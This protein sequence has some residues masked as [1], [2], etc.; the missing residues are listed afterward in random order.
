MIQSSLATK[1]QSFDLVKSEIEQTIRHAETSL[2]RFQE[3]RESGED[4]Q[5]CVDYLNQLRG[6]FVLVELRG[7]TLLCKEAVAVANDVPVGASDDKN[8]LLTTLSTALFILRRYVEYY[9]QQ[10]EDH[11]ELMLPVINELRI[12]RGETPHPESV[13]FE[14]DTAQRPDFCAGVIAQPL[15]LS[16]AEFEAYARRMRLM[17]QVALVGVIRERNEVVSKKLI[18]RAARGF[19]RLCGDGQLKQLWCLLAVVADTM[20]DRAM[21]FNQAR[22]RLLMRIERYGRDMVYVG[23]TTARRTLDEAIIRDLVYLLYRSGSANEEVQ[24]ILSAWN[25]APS[26]Y[27]ESMLEAHRKRLYGPGA[28]VLK[29]LSEALQDELNQLKDRLDIIERGIEPDLSE[30]STIADALRRLANTLSMLDLNR[31]ADMARNEADRLD[32]WERAGALP[33]DSEL[34]A[35]ADSV[36]SIEG[37]VQQM[38][39]RGITS[40]TDALAIARP[41]AREGSL[42]LHEAAIVVGDEARSALTL[43]KRAI[44]AFVESDYDKLHLA[45]LPNTLHSIWGGLQ[46]I[47]DPDA[48]DVMERIAR[49]IQTRLLDVK[50]PPGTAVL[51]SLADALTSLE[52]Y[53][54]TIGTRDNRNPD[55]LRLA[56]AS[57]DDGGL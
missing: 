25:L 33:A 28:D 29:S 54:E 6:I 8:I 36:L 43:A 13:F 11:P 18:A 44:T 57:L 39:T 26:D 51:E 41:E 50:E 48:A 37:A 34:Y 56:E 46:M 16:D 1:S 40:E 24:R 17:F 22:K 12:A 10:R 32:T 3:N 20:T 55:L 9:H 14:L 35:L 31:L 15:D 5:N 19:A 52:Y 4:L 2:E 47:G 49:S 38:V 42:Y 23:R 27:P 21:G 45:N 30:L 53:I 7:G